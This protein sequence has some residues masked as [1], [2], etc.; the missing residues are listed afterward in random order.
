MN[1][2]TLKR[3]ANKQKK[4]DAIFPDKKV[5][6]GARGYEDYTTHKDPKRKENYL[7]RH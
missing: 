1:V 3:S 6:F 7:K 5:S 2:I 4:F